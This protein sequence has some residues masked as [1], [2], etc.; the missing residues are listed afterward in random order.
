MFL[1]MHVIKAPPLSN[2]NRG[3]NGHPKVTEYGNTK[4]FYLSSQS[5]KAA[6]REYFLAYCNL[7]RE[8]YA[9]RSKNHHEHVAQI[10]MAKSPDL[11]PD[12]ALLMAAIVM[13][14]FNS[15]A[16]NIFRTLEK[17]EGTNLVY[18][19]D[20][21]RV[22]IAETALQHR[23]L[24]DGLVERA[25][26]WLKIVD[27]AR[28]DNSDEKGASKLTKLYKDFNE[29]PTKKEL[30]P[31]IRALDRDIKDAPLGF[32][33]V[34]A[35]MMASMTSVSEYAAAQVGHAMSTNVAPAMGYMEDGRWQRAFASS[36]DFFVAF[37]T[38][39]EGG[40]TRSAHIGHRPLATPCWYMNANLNITS[41]IEKLGDMDLALKITGAFAE[42]FAMVLPHGMENSCAH[43]V[44]PA[45]FLMRLHKRQP[46][47]FVQA[48]DKPVE[49]GGGVI[50]ASVLRL[51]DHERELTKLYGTQ[52]QTLCRTVTGLPEACGRGE[53]VLSLEAAI[54]AI[55]QACHQFQET[56]ASAQ[57]EVVVHV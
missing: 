25:E 20:G 51:F 29:G 30:Q 9:E 7:P 39:S 23:E 35:R 24:L 49:E 1:E 13:A 48:F 14:V 3:E 16:E 32:V 6:M 12:K 8:V 33:A 57:K 2:P 34:F 17:D 45:M 28:E 42:A 43:Q 21:E 18:L 26:R 40:D 36:V 53:N 15:S 47:S 10:L 46:L 31:L 37:D 44:P 19:S 27:T 56:S 38:L 54:A 55:T 50:K 41:L 5:I 52:M 11:T 4:R 22:A